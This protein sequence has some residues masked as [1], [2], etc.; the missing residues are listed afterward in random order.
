VVEVVDVVDEGEEV[1][2]VGMDIA[3]AGARAQ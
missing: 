1:E 3:V 2:L